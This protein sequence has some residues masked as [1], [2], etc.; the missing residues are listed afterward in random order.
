MHKKLRELQQ[1]AAEY[2]FVLYR[3]AKHLQWRHPN[4]AMVFTGQTLSDRRA[5][6]QVADGRPAGDWE[7]VYENRVI[8]RPARPRNSAGGSSLFT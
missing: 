5:W 6:R 3:R 2:D 4:G 7:A 1:I 8:Q